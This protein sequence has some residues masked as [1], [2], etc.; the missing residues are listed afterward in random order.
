MLMTLSDSYQPHVV[1]VPDSR[2][3]GQTLLLPK[4][5]L[6]LKARNLEFGLLV[7]AFLIH[8]LGYTL[9]VFGTRTD[10]DVD[11]LSLALLPVALSVLV[12]LILRFS[13][14]NADPFLLPIGTLLTGIGVVAI[15]RLDI[16]EG[17]QGWEADSVRQLVWWGIS[18][19][20]AGAV[21]LV[22][23]NQRILSK[24]TYIAM[25]L[26]I[27]GLVL[28]LFPGIGL[29]VNGATIWVRIAGMFTFQPGEIAKILLAIFFA[30]YLVQHREILTSAG[31]KVLG[32]Q[33]PRAKD[34]GPILMVWLAS[35]AVLI[36]QRDLGTGLLY[37][38]LFLVMLYQASGKSSWIMIGLA[39]FAGGA[40]WAYLTIDRVRSRFDGWINA[41]DDEV[42]NAVGGSYQVV[43][44][45]FGLAKGGLI[46]TGLGRGRPDITPF[47]ENDFIF[48]SIGEELGLTGT[49]AILVLYLLLISR[50]FKAGFAVKDD[51][52]KLLS[53]GLSF[54]LALQV[55]IIVGGVTRLIPLTGLTTPFLAAGGSSLL[56]N[57]I[58]LILLMRISHSAN[59]QAILALPVR[60]S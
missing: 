11:F 44:G 17:L 28:P 29:E 22:I 15:H 16:A 30:G 23:K 55:F 37:F 3:A 2:D 39:L 20:V 25:A 18:L 45:L 9:V 1:T 34:L 40:Y 33:F 58:I 7:F 43:Q 49:F 10:F 51:F 41:F 54:T 27:I 59:S 13:A 26:G 14:P 46:G 36:F 6:R 12:H 5:K 38:G 21:I 4:P 35:I 32:L 19:G 31:P 60:K 48:A 42:Y 57:W 53:V 52:S 8:F 24:Y 56:A 47:A 50:G